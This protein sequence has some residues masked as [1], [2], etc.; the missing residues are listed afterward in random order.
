MQINIQVF[1]EEQFFVE[2]AYESR[3]TFYTICRTV[4]KLF[5]YF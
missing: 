3:Y 1:I 5:R 2:E 4:V